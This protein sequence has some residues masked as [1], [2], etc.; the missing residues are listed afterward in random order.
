M[1]AYFPT[2]CVFSLPQGALQLL[3]IAAGAATVAAH[4]ALAAQTIV[5]FLKKCWLQV[6]AGARSSRVALSLCPA[7]LFQPLC[8]LIGTMS[9]PESKS[10]AEAGRKT[11]ES[12][13]AA[14]LEAEFKAVSLGDRKEADTT[15]PRSVFDSHPEE[16]KAGGVVGEEGEIIPATEGQAAKIMD[17]FRMYGRCRWCGVVCGN[18]L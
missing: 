7:A 3:A 10:S 1:T 12:D 6:S 8:A 4:C 18:A 9:S 16:A 11:Q 17:G 15:A 5:C 2:K 13:E 14:A